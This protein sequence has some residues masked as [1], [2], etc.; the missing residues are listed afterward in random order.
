MIRFSRQITLLL[1]F[2]FSGPFLVESGLSVHNIFQL[3]GKSA[4]ISNQSIKCVAGFQI[5]DDITAQKDKHVANAHRPSD[6]SAT[7]MVTSNC[8]SSLQ[9]V[10]DFKSTFSA[11]DSNTEYNS[12]VLLLH[13]QLFAHKIADPPRLG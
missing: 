11:P 13:S 3:S 9:I 4:H 12:Y 6:N 1:L 2:V 5:S 10:T 8:Q 7:T